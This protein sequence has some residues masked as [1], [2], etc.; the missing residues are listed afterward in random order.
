MTCSE[1]I[2]NVNHK[3]LI[4]AKMDI[5]ELAQQHILKQPLYVTGKPI[6]YTAREFGLDPK[7]IDKLASNENPFGPSP[8]G[9]EEARKALEEVLAD[10]ARVHGGTAGDDEDV[11][12]IPQCSEDD[13]ALG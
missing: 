11:F 2:L 13:T 8:K 5:N 3:P 6:A 4:T 1:R 9:M 7:D 12:Q 10:H